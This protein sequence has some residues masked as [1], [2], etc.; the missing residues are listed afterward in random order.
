LEVEKKLRR[1]KFCQSD[2]FVKTLFFF[3]D[4]KKDRGSF[5]IFMLGGEVQDLNGFFS[6]ISARVFFIRRGSVTAHTIDN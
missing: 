3:Q 4:V 5:L 1:K 2:L 6:G